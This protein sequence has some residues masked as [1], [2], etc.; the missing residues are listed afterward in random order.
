VHFYSK[1]LGKTQ[2]NTG[3]PTRFG[4]TSR[5]TAPR[6][7]GPRP[8]APGH[9]GVR[10]PR[11]LRHRALQG[12]LKSPLLAQCANRTPRPTGRT[13]R[14]RTGGHRGGPPC[15]ARRPRPWA[16]RCLDG[17]GRAQVQARA[18]LRSLPI[19]SS[20]PCSGLRPTP[21]ATAARELAPGAAPPPLTPAPQRSSAP[22]LAPQQLAA[23]PQATAGGPGRRHCQSWRPAPLAAGAPH[24]RSRLVPVRSTKPSASDP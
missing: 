18:P 3:T 7:A 2:S 8:R 19:R 10:A 14:R 1:I 21:S 15:R 9:L 11:F 22:T 12:P 4:A 16:P 5:R 20:P 23:H 24:H 17:R 13:D 6:R